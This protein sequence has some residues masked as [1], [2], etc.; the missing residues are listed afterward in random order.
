MTH[1]DKSKHHHDHGHEQS[2]SGHG[3]PHGH[4]AATHDG[5]TV[6]DPVCGM[7]VQLGKGKPSAEWQGKGYHFCSQKCHDRFVADPYFYLSG[8]KARQKQKAASGTLYTCP[9]HPEIVRDKPGACPICGMALEPMSG[10]SDEPN[11]ELIDFTRRMWISAAAAVPL[12]VLTMGGMIGLPIRDWIG[13]QTAAYLEFLLATPVVLWAA[14][15]FFDRGWKS[16]R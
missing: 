14:L 8:N 1:M 15:P 9:M 5:N 11:P 7:T 2:C 16:I 6:T 3:M 12:I 10:V 4:D 13:H